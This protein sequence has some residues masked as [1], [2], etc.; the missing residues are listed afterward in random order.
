MSDNEGA[1]EKSN[2]HALEQG[3]ADRG[4]APAATQTRLVVRTN[5]RSK[6]HRDLACSLASTVASRL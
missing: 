4:E 2:P 1:V 5:S 6:A 3:Q